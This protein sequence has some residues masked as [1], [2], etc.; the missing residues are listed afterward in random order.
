MTLEELLKEHE[1]SVRHDIK[2]YTY[3]LWDGETYLIIKENGERNFGD[4]LDAA[5]DEFLK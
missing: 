1:V 4:N 3:L 5:L 2:D